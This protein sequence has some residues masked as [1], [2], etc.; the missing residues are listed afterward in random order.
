MIITQAQET[1]TGT[2]LSQPDLT[3]SCIN[4]IQFIT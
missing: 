3:V 4:G 2:E 1:T